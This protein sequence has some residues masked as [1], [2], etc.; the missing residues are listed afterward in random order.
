MFRDVHPGSGS[1]I[2]IFLPI[3]DPGSRGQGTTG[4]Q[5][6]ATLLETNFRSRQCRLQRIPDGIVK[7][8]IRTANTG[9]DR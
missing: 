4:S 1:R 2:L 9:P 7:A 8:R 5:T 3:P 6:P